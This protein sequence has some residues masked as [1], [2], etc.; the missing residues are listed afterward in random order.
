M[1]DFSSSVAN[2]YIVIISTLLNSFYFS[3][4]AQN[5][6]FSQSFHHRLLVGLPYPWTAFSDLHCFSD[7]L[8]SPACFIFLL[9]L[10][11]GLREAQ[12]CRY[13]FYSVVQN[14]TLSLQVRSPCQISRLPGQKSGILPQTI[15]FSHFGHKFA[16]Q[17]R[18][19]CTIFR[20]SSA[21]IRV[22]RSLFNFYI[23]RFRRT[24]NQVISI[25]PR[26]RHFPTNFQ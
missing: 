22:Y 15:N 17:G 16:P 7:L 1:F 4:W 24:N 3:L 23:G 5:L 11:T 6:S 20:T 8:C 9:L 18:L 14:D 26:W 10:S 12:P 25:F 2:M 13:C 19:V 21:F